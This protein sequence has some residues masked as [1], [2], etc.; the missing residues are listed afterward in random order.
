MSYFLIGESSGII[1]D[2]ETVQTPTDHLNR[3]Q[4]MHRIRNQ[5]WRK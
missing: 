1:L 2:T 4:S 5:F 3:F